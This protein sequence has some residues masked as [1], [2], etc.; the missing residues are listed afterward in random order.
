[1]SV[2]SIPFILPHRLEGRKNIFAVKVNHYP[3][4]A[5][6]DSAPPFMSHWMKFFLR[7]KSEKRCIVKMFLGN[8]PRRLARG[9]MCLFIVGLAFYPP[10]I[11]I[12]SAAAQGKTPSSIA[13]HV[14]AGE[15]GPARAAADGL[16]AEG[17]DRALA[18]IAAAQANSGARDASLATAY[19]IRSDQTRR[20]T[21]DQIR[22][23]GP[24]SSYGGGSAGFVGND[25]S[26]GPRGGGVVA[27]FDSL[28]DLITT[29]IDPDSW[30]DVGGPGTIAEF[31]TGV[32]VDAAGLLKKYNGD[33]DRSLSE[34]RKSAA[35]V[36]SS[37]NPRRTSILR[38][39]SLTR[40]EREAQFLHAQGKTPDAVMRN[41]AGLQ[42]IQFVLVYPETGDIVL[43]GPAGDWR[44]DDDGRMVDE[45]GRP[46]VQLDD[47]VVTLR[48]AYS[49]SGRFGCAI[50]PTKEGLAAIQAK[51]AEWATRSLTSTNRGE[52]LEDLRSA[53]G[54]QDITTH[55]IDP[56]THA[57][58]V[59]VEADYRMKLVGMGLEKGAGTTSYLD[60]VELAKGEAPPPTNVLRWWFT[61]NY[62]ALRSAPQ[63][64][65]FQLH[66]SGVKVLSENEM[67]SERG[68]RVHTGKSSDLNSKFARGF[69]KNFEVLAG[70][71]PI[72]ADLRNVFDLALVAALIKSEDLPGQVGWHM[73]HFGPDGQYEP[74]LGIAP[75]KVDSVVNYRLINGNVVTAGVSGGVVVD[76]RGLAQKEAVKLDE[77]GTLKGQRQDAA[78]KELPRG[79]WWWD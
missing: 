41:L 47:L 17:R 79:A 74:A 64:D 13:A 67:L 43:A 19:D 11:L 4:N 37:R 57:A 69:T 56:R 9:V 53:L 58:R 77:Y 65:A 33:I 61:L 73:T 21:F 16:S 25:P 20:G 22:S 70:K 10:S 52:F 63:N 5:Q 36:G 6:L 39:I 46:V 72:Y 14:E 27:D 76:A 2:K 30:E 26:G 24:S 7:G 42:R 49:E 60:S 15:F 62:D 40:L 54:K 78:P 48:N 1:M 38:K 12:R 51:Q 68:E 23:S 3:R 35:I 45:K 34:V 44:P 71:Y 29:T 66:G 28:I 8:A 31:A 55:G 75:S 50:V 59:I 18:I 32:Y